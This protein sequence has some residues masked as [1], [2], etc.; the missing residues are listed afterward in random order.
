MPCAD[1][2]AEHE[3]GCAIRPALKNVRTTSFL[4]NGMQ[5]KSLDQL[6]HVVLIGWIAQP[7]LQPFRLRLTDFGIITDDAELARQFDTSVKVWLI[8][9]LEMC[10]GIS[11]GLIYELADAEQR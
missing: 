10:L 11:A 5:V 4:T 8:L 1:V 6:Q 9:T 7:D 2:A 3:R